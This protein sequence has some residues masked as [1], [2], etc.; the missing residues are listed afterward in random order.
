M[1]VC[2]CLGQFINS[3][4]LSLARHDDV[5]LIRAGTSKGAFTLEG[6]KQLRKINL[7]LVDPVQYI[8][9]IVAI[10]TN[11]R[12]NILVRKSGHLEVDA[13]RKNVC[14]CGY[15]HHGRSDH[16]ETSNRNLN[17]SLMKLRKSSEKRQKQFQT[18]IG[19]NFIANNIVAEC[20]HNSIRKVQLSLRRDF[21]LPIAPKRQCS[22]VV[23]YTIL[24]T[25]TSNT[26]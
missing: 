24:Q 20:V 13:P 21:A 6:I 26:P 22:T 15:T 16:S 2:A 4:R 10:Y 9:Y 19:T 14:R 23:G 7:F 5:H 17:I 25:P 18:L 11:M 8:I 3:C 1:R 12:V